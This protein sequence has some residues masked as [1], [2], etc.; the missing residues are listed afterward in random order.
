M[1]HWI[2]KLKGDQEQLQRGAEQ[3]SAAKTRITKE[4]EDYHLTSPLFTEDLNHDEVVQWAT[5]LLEVMKWRDRWISSTLP[6]VQVEEVYKL[7]D[8]G[9]RTVGAS[10]STVYSIHGPPPKCFE[11][12]KAILEDPD[13]FE[14][15]LSLFHKDKAVT[16]ALRHWVEWAHD[17][18]VLYCVLETVLLDLGGNKKAEELIKN[19]G[20]VDWKEVELFK[21]TSQFVSATGGEG[22][23]GWGYKQGTPPQKPM[24]R[25]SAQQL[26]KRLLIEWLLYRL[27]RC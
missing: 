5:Q 19:K 7:C 9:T 17:W 1:F 8:D 24:S 22:R 6:Q 14:K 15:V 23:H 4:D 12:F 11:Q 27:E 13:E 26:V 18:R 20:W 3:L 16:W 25:S 21:Q 10:L 2:V